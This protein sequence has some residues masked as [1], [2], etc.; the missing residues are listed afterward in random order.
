MRMTGNYS[1]INACTMIIRIIIFCLSLGISLELPAQIVSEEIPGSNFRFPEN[2][3]CYKPI[4]QENTLFNLPW[5]FV[6][7][8]YSR[9]GIIKELP[10]L[11]AI[12]SLYEFISPLDSIPVTKRERRYSEDAA[13]LLLK[14]YRWNNEIPGWTPKQRQ[15]HNYDITGRE[16]FL[17]TFEWDDDLSQW[18]KYAKDS[19]V[20]NNTNSEIDYYM[21]WVQNKW[22]FVR[23][24]IQQWDDLNRYIL[25][26]HYDFDTLSN[27][28]QGCCKNEFYYDEEGKMIQELQYSWDTNLQDF[29]VWG[30]QESAY[31]DAG[32]VMVSIRF[33][34]DESSGEWINWE[35]R[36]F[37]YHPDGSQTMDFFN[38]DLSLEQWILKTRSDYFVD[39]AGNFL[40]MESFDYDQDTEIPIQGFKFDYVLN[41]QGLQMLETYYRWNVEKEEWYVTSKYFHQYGYPVITYLNEPENEEIVIYPN[42]TNDHFFIDTAEKFGEA[43]LQIYTIQG[44]LMLDQ[45][46]RSGMV[47]ISTLPAGLYL[48]QLNLPGRNPVIK[49]L[50]IQ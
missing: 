20:Y 36:E 43:S 2:I 12:D 41:D 23:K 19:L 29:I 25:Y 38:W 18:I 45:S 48:L 46:N 22:I 14:E 31:D 34:S 39:E 26:A 6:Q 27:E 47:D 37:S 4:F 1:G 33:L 24:S 9:K 30:K 5:N 7:S 50:I 10:Y 32:E 17:F 8:H 15:V 49:Q 35:K 40:G 44:I 11:I 13:L 21:E 16:Q 3:P 28:W 42:P